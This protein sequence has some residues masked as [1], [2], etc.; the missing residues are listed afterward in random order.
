MKP[1]VADLFKRQSLLCSRLVQEAKATLDQMDTM[2]EEEINVAMTK[3]L[4]VKMGMPKH[5]QLMHML[6]EPALLKRMEKLEG[7]VRSDQ[8][9]GM[10]QE[11]QADLFFAMDERRN[12]ADLTEKGRVAISGDDPDAFVLPDLV[13]SLQDIEQNESLSFEERLQAKQQFQESFAAKSERLQNISQLLR[14]YCLFEK[15]VHYVVSEGKVLIVDEHT[16]RILPGRRFSDG[17][18]QALE[19]KEDVKIEKETQTLAT[20]TIQNYF[21][22]YEKLAGMTG[23]AETEANDFHQIYKLDVVVIPTNKTCLRVDSNDCVY[24]TKREK[25]NAIVDETEEAWRR[26]QPVLVGTISVDDSEI[27]SRLLKRRGIPH[28]VLNA[29][30][31]ERESEIVA[32]AGQSGAVT[33]ATNMAG[34]GTDIKLGPG[35]AEL[36]TTPGV[37]T[38][39]CAAVLRVRVTRVHPTSTFRWKTV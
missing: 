3:L 36:G 12:E 1:A 34:R 31:H 23:T 28:N 37:L 4:Q 18:H 35:V 32:R 7:M 21:R 16:G 15:D 25:F 10:L 33:V 19:A 5:K 8:N 39:S 20:I 13:N 26:G 17:L 22:M 30:N 38:A 27:V 11:V 6:Q 29:K 2:P 9:R 14:A 24:K